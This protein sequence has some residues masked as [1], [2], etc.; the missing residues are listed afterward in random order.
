MR[1]LTLCLPVAV[2]ICASVAADVT[3]VRDGQAVA[4]IVVPTDC[5]AQV[6]SAAA[7][8]VSHIRL[9]SGAKLPIVAEAELQ[10][11][12]DD[13]LVLLGP[14]ALWPAAFP[15]GFDD[16][17]FTIRTAGRAVSI[18]GPSDWGT[19]FGVYDLLER[20]VGVRWLMPGEDGT[21][22]PP[23]TTITI[24]ESTVAEQP[25][26]FSRLFSGLQ[27]T[28]QTAW[29][30]FNRMRGRV[31]FHHNLRNL[32]NWDTYPKTHPE[33]F[34]LIDGKRFLP[35]QRE[36]WQPC[37]TAEGSVEE[38]VRVIT[39]YFD[40]DPSRT[41]YSLGINDNRNFCQCDNC[42]AKIGDGENFLG[43]PDYSD[44]YYEWCNSVVEGVLTHHPDKWFGLLAYHYVGA[45]PQT[46]HVHPRIIPYMTYDRMKWVHPQLRADGEAATRA[47]AQKSPT[48]GWYDYIY[49]R[50]YQLPRVWFHHMADYYRF[51]R[52]NGVRAL[53]AEAYPNWGEGPKLYVSLKL[54]WNPDQSVDDLLADWYAACGGEKAAPLLAR[55]YEFWE[56]FWTRRIPESP[57]FRLPG[58]Y[59]S[60]RG[61]PTYL[62]EVTD[63]ELGECRV[64][65]EQ[66]LELTETD[67]QRAR[68][69]TVLDT[70][71]F[72]EASA[73]CYQVGA[74]AQ[75]PPGSEAEA[76]ARIDRIERAMLLG[77]ERDRLATEVFAD[78]PAL[79]NVTE[80]LLFQSD[81]GQMEAV[82]SVLDYAAHE[83]G[84]VAARVRELAPKYA[85][86]A[87][88]ETIA[89]VL[90]AHETPARL[91]ERITNGGFEDDGG[92]AAAP[93]GPDWTSDGAPAGWSKW[94]RPGT[95]AQML[96]T[97]EDAHEGRRS[98][99]ITTATAC[100]FLQRIEVKP[101]EHY[102]LSGYVKARVGQGAL[103]R[104]GVQWQD[105]KGTWSDAPRIGIDVPP[106]ETAGWQHLRAFLR[107]PDG[108]ARA[109]VGLSAQSQGT[110]DYAFFDGI[111]FKQMPAE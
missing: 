105:D 95:S 18:C 85:G 102:L 56:Q 14:V 103:T 33:F 43:Y 51:G 42:R 6:K 63:E 24:P 11:G 36:G 91:I 59:L 81:R 111:S 5:S 70:F 22:V 52:D 62:L 87:M 61:E 34:P 69:Q 108:V 97:T 23:H 74:E 53:Y 37:F 58:Q 44:L 110:G 4:T 107:V 84:A 49:G 16:D 83:G 109:V 26:F 29:A 38:A 73:L 57:W 8:L 88:A 30:R 72:Y 15:E 92:A 40:E 39:A 66:A 25:V 89:A 64:L 55:Y 67:A 20:H 35:T 76:L 7:A 100:S 28:P 1:L 9:S 106:G 19:E 94:V 17:G 12:P 101:G 41:S 13:P 2:L 27:G 32:F 50:P 65:L 21:H 71:S 86:T 31:Q 82:M 68:V 99:K 104:L 46:I 79:R 77:R 47:W 80:N 10:A 98:V 75:Q 90:M 78:H 48:L 45:P 93:A 3:L 96:R 60:H 54:Q